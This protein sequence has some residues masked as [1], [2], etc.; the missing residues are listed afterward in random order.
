MQR[1]ILG[2]SAALKSRRPTKGAAA[3]AAAGAESSPLGR[4]PVMGPQPE[5]API[6]AAAPTVFLLLSRSV[7]LSRC[8]M[9]PGHNRWEIVRGRERCF[10][11]IGNAVLFSYISSHPAFEAGGRKGGNKKPLSSRRSFSGEP[12]GNGRFPTNEPGERRF[13][14]RGRPDGGAPTAGA[15]AGGGSFRHGRTVSLLIEKKEKAEDHFLYFLL[16]GPTGFY[17]PRFGRFPRGGGKNP[18]GPSRLC[19]Q[20]GGP[21]PS[22]LFGAGAAVAAPGFGGGGEDPPPGAPIPLR[23]VPAGGGRGGLGGCDCRLSFNVIIVAV[24][25]HRITPPGVNL[26]TMVGLREIGK[27]ATEGHSYITA[28]NSESLT[29]DPSNYPDDTSLQLPPPR[30]EDAAAR[31]Y[32]DG[33]EIG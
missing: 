4:I 27:C 28:N 9:R 14:E 19:V 25:T 6:R 20:T 23:S 32:G 10:A 7:L 31:G 30:C 1:E 15:A 8:F 33:E 24:V 21:L 26:V 22:T 16:A 5:P 18:E 29:C 3:A 17:F 11:V 12:I 13:A 2:Q